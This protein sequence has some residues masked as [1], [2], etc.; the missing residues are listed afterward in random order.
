MK[1]Q[2][3]KDFGSKEV[4]IRLRNGRVIVGT[5][6]IKEKIVFLIGRDSKKIG[7]LPQEIVE[8]EEV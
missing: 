2:E 5:F 3:I 7:I 8:I 6:S 1:I 4:K